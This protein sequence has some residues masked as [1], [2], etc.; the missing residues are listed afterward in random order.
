ME[1]DELIM[2]AA[3][4]INEASVDQ[5][6]NE[7]HTARDR[8]LQLHELLSDWLITGAPKPEDTPTAEQAT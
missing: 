2:Q 3:R 7:P 5:A 8:L 4:L 1:Q 6:E